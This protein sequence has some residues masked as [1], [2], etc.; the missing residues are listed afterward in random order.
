MQV[1]CRHMAVGVDR[2]V[3][4]P[5]AQ[6]AT[7]VLGPQQN[8]RMRLSPGLLYPILFR[9]GRSP[10]AKYAIVMQRV[11]PPPLIRLGMSKRSFIQLLST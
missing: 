5:V 6:A 4:A 9:M 8:M 3:L 2:R 11:T 10:G 7:P 1:T